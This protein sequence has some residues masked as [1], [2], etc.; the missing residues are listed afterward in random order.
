VI[1]VVFTLFLTD[2]IYANDCPE[3]QILDCS[4]VCWPDFYFQPDNDYCEDG[5]GLEENTNYPN[6]SCLDWGFD[7]AECDSGWLGDLGTEYYFCMGSISGGD[8]ADCSGEPNGDA[9]LDNCGFCDDNT[10]NDCVQDCEGTWGG[11]FW[12]SD[13]GCVP[14]DNTG[15][16]CDD[17]NGVP[18]GD[19]WLSDCGCVAWDNTGDEC[20]D[21]TGVPFGDSWVS[22]CGCVPANNTGDECDDCNGIPNGDSWISDCGCVAFDNTGDECDD[23]NGIPNGDSW[24][25][26]CG[27]VAF[28]N[29]GD[30]CDDC[31]GIPNGDAIIDECGVCDGT[32][33]PNGHCDCDGNV[34]DCNNECG[35]T[36]ILDNCGICDSDI[37][38][39]CV[40][41]CNGEW[42]GSAQIDHCG[43]CDTSPDNDC[44]QDCN[45]IWG[46]NAEY[47]ACGICD[48]TGYDCDADGLPA[49]GSQL[50]NGLNFGNYSSAIE[51]ECLDENGWQDNNCDGVCDCC[52]YSNGIDCNYIGCYWVGTE[53]YPNG[54]CVTE[55]ELEY[56]GWQGPDCLHDC[57]GLNELSDSLMNGDGDGVCLIVTNWDL[58]CYEDCSIEE[59]GSQEFI[60]ACTACLAGEFPCVDIFSNE[61]EEVCDINDY[62]P[63]ICTD[64]DDDGCD[65]CSRGI[66]NPSNDGNDTDGDGLCDDGD[67]EPDCATNNTDECGLCGGQGI[68]EGECDCEGNV[69][70]CNNVCGGDAILDNCGI[71]DNDLSNNCVPD[72]NGVWGGNNQLDECG[73]CDNDLS[74]NCVPDC[75]GV[76]GG[77]SQ[78]DECGICDGPGI[79]EGECDCEGHV[80]DCNNVCGGDAILDN[81]G[82]CD[83]DLS[84]DC[85]PDCNGDWGGNALEDN[86]GVCDSYPWND[87]TEDC[88]GVWG[89]NAQL[90]EC[91]VCDGPG[92]PA[93]HCDCNG[94]ILDCSETCGGNAEFDNCGNCDDDPSNDCVP[95]CNGDWGGSAL[96]DNCGICDSYPWND[97]TEDCN[98]VWGGNT[99]VDFCGVC[100]GGNYSEPCGAHS[101]SVIDVPNDQGYQLFI[102]FSKSIYD[103]D[104][105]VTRSEV[106]SL[107]LKHIGDTWV[108][109]QAI[110]AYGAD[111]YTVLVPTLY[112]NVESE[113]R[114]IANM[115]E[116]NFLT[117]EEVIGTAIDNIVPTTPTNLAGN[118]VDDLLE[119]SWDY[120]IEDDF[121]YHAVTDVWGS[122]SYTTENHAAINIL[123]DQ[124]PYNEFWVNSV[125]INGNLSPDSEYI[126][127][128]VLSEGQNLVS[129]SILP[130]DNS[131]VNVIQGTGSDFSIIGILGEG[132]AASYI[133]TD[134]FGNDFYGW[135][136]SLIYLSP[137]AGYWVQSTKDDFLMLKGD[138]IHDTATE[139]HSGSNLISYNC[140]TLGSVEELVQ[141]PCVKGILGQG[142]ATSYIDGMGWI[143]SLEYL[144]PGSGY[145]FQVDSGCGY[146]DYDYECAEYNQSLSRKIQDKQQYEQ[147]FVQSMQQAFY[148]IGKID[149][150][151]EGD[152]VEAYNGNIKVGSRVWEGNFTDIPVMGNDG[153][154]YSSAFCK[155]GDIPTFKLIK[156]SGEMYNIYGKIPPFE[157]NAIFVIDSVDEVKPSPVG[158][159]IHSVYPNPFNPVTTLEFS[160]EKEGMVSLQVFDLN[161]RMVEEILQKNL[162]H[163]YHSINWN[164]Q[165]FSSGIYFINILVDGEKTFTQKVVFSK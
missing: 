27:C 102:S 12:E 74:N 23:C 165:E 4:E 87:C 147:G 118:R 75:N 80:F 145:W 163:G 41:D 78:L 62:D 120:Y 119:L 143:G 64:Q 44:I 39:D 14:A 125:D 36:G 153:M 113:F 30:E 156:K 31:N 46:G 158:F 146:V 95:D 109:I 154:E 15:D 150:A 43:I 17:C 94:N 152:I 135:F 99:T 114:L 93:G 98:G 67:P 47:D 160:I 122:P 79:L 101:V 73:I 50:L 92:I 63:N 142:I 28:D 138:K 105:L 66:Y 32:G 130:E 72:C 141:E 55:S 68:P 1:W 9:E 124:Y 52:N 116:G 117:N 129:F 132:V 7:G 155:T 19:S 108:T 59:F 25:S 89:G 91:S 96:E 40:P 45:G 121:S 3:G 49:C 42:G 144:V 134:S 133:Y 86:C 84:N 58:G 38:N 51:R 18:N 82:T 100:G 103:T 37:S 106:Y 126:A 136:G 127:S 11:D 137:N 69:F 88:N 81:C 56:I 48:G 33:I 157:N 53:E 83:N 71:C 131:L 97:C 20:D 21:C 115:D 6:F 85:V 8:C 61:D 110:G 161:G 16:E 148:F 65:D 90:D 76:W 104:T 35:G 77:N 151:E 5:Q 13:C 29:T 10:L 149:L 26:D 70:D 162:T 22:D 24:I 111:T 139:L 54:I 140:S 107:E 2:A 112:N 164:A 57:G 34:L 123:A 128:Y 60:E 159:Q